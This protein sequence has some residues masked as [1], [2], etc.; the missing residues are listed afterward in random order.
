MKPAHL[1]CLL[2]LL[3]VPAVQADVVV[4]GL[5]KGGVLLVI[6]GEQ[7]LLKTGQEFKGVTLVEANSQ[8]AIAEID[9]QQQTL[10]ISTHITT[11]YAEPPITTVRIPKNQR[12]QYITTALINGR[13]TRVLVDTG[14]NVVA[15]NASTARSLGLD[16]KQGR[17]HQV[18]T[19]SGI[20]TAYHVKLEKIDVGGLVVQHVDA[21]VMEGAQPSTVLLGTSYL[22]HVQL[23]E[24]DGVLMLMQR[25]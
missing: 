14:A 21:S 23:S 4:K 11:R 20:V 22:Q 13:S 19:A 9:G 5:F 16:Y 10:L 12:R 15:L 17:V 2:S 8:R 7:K 1:I 18:E 24:K 25:R 6:D 3:L